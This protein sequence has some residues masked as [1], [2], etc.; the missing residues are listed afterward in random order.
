[1]LVSSR[2][3]FLRLEATYR[4]SHIA[5]VVCF[6]CARCSLFQAVIR[7]VVPLFLPSLPSLNGGVGKYWVGK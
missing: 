6:C 3:G 5:H 7:S 2:Q 1:M 4:V